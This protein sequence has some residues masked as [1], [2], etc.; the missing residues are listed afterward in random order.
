MRS[1][2][3]LSFTI[4]LSFILCQPSYAINRDAVATEREFR[5]FPN[6]LRLSVNKNLPIIPEFANE[7]ELHQFA[8][9]KGMSIAEVK[10]ELRLLARLSLDLSSKDDARYITAREIID[11][12]ERVAESGLD[13]SYVLMLNGRYIGKN[14]QDFHTAIELYQQAAN[15]LPATKNTEEQVLLFTIYEHLGVLHMMLRQK[16]PA[17][18]YLMSSRSVALELSDPYMR[19]HIESV[20][21]KY[22]YKQAQFGKSLSHYSEAIMHT[23][24]EDNPTQDA[25]IQLQLAR[26]YREL[27]SWDDA[28]LYATAA[29]DSYQR[30]GKETY[31][32]S[33]MTVMAM[34]YA[35]QGQWYKTIDYYLNAQQIDAK[36]G[37]YMGQALNFHNLGEAYYKI[38]DTKNA[39]S[40]L[41]RASDIFVSRNS[42]HYLVYNHLLIAQV[43]SSLSEWELALKY[44][45]SAAN[46]ADDMKLN[47]E[48][49]EALN[50]SAK[51]L[52]QLGDFKTAYQHIKRISTLQAKDTQVVNDE[53][54]AKTLFQLQKIK[55]EQSQT[56]T[57]LQKTKD[58]LSNSQLALIITLLVLSLMTVLALYLWRI[59]KTLRAQSVELEKNSLLDPLTQIANHAA[60]IR[61]FNYYGNT[62]KTL[63]LISLTDQLNSDLAQGYECNTK[64]NR[65]QLTALSNELGCIIYF[66][67]PGVFLLNFDIQVNPDT[68]LNNIR[69]CLIDNYGDTSLHMGLVSLPL[70]T[71]PALKLSAEQHFGTLQM[72]LSAATTLG[73][74]KDYFVT[75]KPLNFASSGIFI[76]PLYLNIEKSIIRG[77]IKIETN[78]H[79]SDIVWPRWKSHKNVNLSTELD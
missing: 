16:D 57:D 26:V 43:Y 32:S 25:H 71:N 9:Q 64:M 30:L 51:A 37:N 38:E 46:I 28:I 68:L 3:T 31:V 76:P 6:K 70:L 67:R 66:I 39:I 8:V 19:A 74:D 36:L 79:K 47:D 14:K 65:Q 49:I 56:K 55:L 52:E 2:F 78:G 27:K 60:F 53:E 58:E 33:A 5:E 13:S 29:S 34:I 45:N 21:G 73:D 42:N 61:D 48:H 7:N 41:L 4:L 54:Q 10:Q 69:N 72:M 12:L 75:L 59:K 22:Y 24:T 50:Y 44:A 1:L 35:E 11:Q 15:E 23:K 18:Q 63:A 17:L 40:H 62:F 20:L 77:I